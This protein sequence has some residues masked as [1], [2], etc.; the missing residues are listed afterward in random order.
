MMRQRLAEGGIKLVKGAATSAA[1]P[2]H[3]QKGEEKVTQLSSKF[4]E[5]HVNLQLFDYSIRA[6][7]Y[8]SG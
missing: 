2:R 7:S 5:L 8:R 6:N 3:K 1:E 4:L